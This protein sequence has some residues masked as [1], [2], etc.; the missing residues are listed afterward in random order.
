MGIHLSITTSLVPSYPC[1][2]CCSNI[3]CFLNSVYLLRTDQ[4]SNI[5]LY[6]RGV[7]CRGVNLRGVNCR[8]ANCR[9]QLSGGIVRNFPMNS[10]T[11][12]EDFRP[13][14][15]STSIQNPTL[16]SYILDPTDDPTPTP[17]RL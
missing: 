8:G 7:N 9:G 2:L 17:L 16:A 11:S 5:K 13:L 6:C 14:L 1:S 3:C 10:S 15:N 4:N 12:S